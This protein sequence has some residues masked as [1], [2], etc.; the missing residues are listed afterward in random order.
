LPSSKGSS[1]GFREEGNPTI[2]AQN[3]FGLVLSAI[4]NFPCAMAVADPEVPELIYKEGDDPSQGLVCCYGGCDFRGFSWHSI[5]THVRLRHGRKYANLRGTY[6]YRKGTEES[7]AMQNELR[8]K[9]RLPDP[10]A[11]GEH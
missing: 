10:A 9:R 1:R 7:N 4:S 11:Q 2:N 3:L 5:F 6:L 8:R